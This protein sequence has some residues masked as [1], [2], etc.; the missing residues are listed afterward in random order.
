[1]SILR[2]GTR[3]LTITLAA[4]TIS[5][6]VGAE[7]IDDDTPV[8]PAGTPG[9]PTVPLTGADLEQWIRGR[10]VF[11]RDWRL[12]QGLGTP[13]LNADSCRSCHQHPVIGAAGQL[14]TN[15]F[16][17]GADNNGNGPFVDLPGGQIA[18]KLRRVDVP[19]REDANGAADVFEVRQTPSLLGIG[20]LET[21]PESAILANEDPFDTDGDGVR[22]VARRIAIGGAFEVGRYGWKAQIP[23]VSD[24]VRDAVS[25]EIGITLPDDGRGFGLLTD[26][27]PVPDPE[28]VDADFDDALFFLMNLAPPPRAGGTDPAIPQGEALFST[29]GCATCHIPTLPGAGG[30]VSLYSDLLLHDIHPAEFRGMAEPDAPVGMYRTPPLWGVRDTSPYLHDGSATTLEDAIL[31]HGDEALNART[32]YEQ[33]T[34]GEQDALLLFLEDL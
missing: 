26:S 34:A 31:R 17:F 25:E 10:K 16:R 30:P 1:M 24:F 27:D 4:L 2:R 32:N 3:L 8:P 14:D 7:V 18:S 28:I 5:T 12:D 11:D 22:G 21:I 19:G 6:F 23:T 33:L 13:E 20:L 29:I 15:V 9:G